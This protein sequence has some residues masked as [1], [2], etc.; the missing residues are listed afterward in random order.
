MGM[1]MYPT[2]SVADTDKVRGG[3]Y[4]PEPIAEFLA[5]W[6]SGAGSKLLEPSCGDGRILR[7]LSTISDQASGVELVKRKQLRL[8]SMRR[9]STRAF[10]TGSLGVSASGGTE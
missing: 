7:K 9:S 10:S 2:K 1:T 3:Y 6:V 8:G 4:T 5:A